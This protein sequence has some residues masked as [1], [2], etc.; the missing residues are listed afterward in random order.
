MGPLLLAR[1]STV[2]VFPRG[3]FLKQSAVPELAEPDLCMQARSFSY[4]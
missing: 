3:G 4:R 2:F 1:K